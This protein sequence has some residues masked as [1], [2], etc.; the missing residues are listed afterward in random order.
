MLIQNRKILK[1]FPFD[2]Y[3][4]LPGYSY[5]GICSEGRTKIESPTKKM[6]LGT[7]VG[8]YLLDPLAY[9]YSDIEIV[10]PLALHLNKF[11]GKLMKY[12]EAELAV[13]CNMVLD[14]ISMP[15]KG[16]ADLGIVDR[17]V[18]DIKVTEMPLHKFI[19]FFRSDRQV[20]GYC[21]ALNADLGFI[22]AINPKTKLITTKQITI[23]DEWWH[24]QI[25]RKGEPIHD[26]SSKFI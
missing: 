9:D 5:S 1:T 24:Y 2:E 10:R 4:K 7:K 14:G 15:Y 25:S 11:L 12:C 18:I 22:V 13:T 21:Y 8:Q 23:D 6:Q 20:S 16:R 19:D 26:S 17:L 3:L